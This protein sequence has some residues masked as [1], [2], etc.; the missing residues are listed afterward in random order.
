MRLILTNFN[1]VLGLRGYISFAENKPLLIY[2]ENIAGK[3]N[4][5]NVLRYCLIPKVKEKKGYTEEKRLNKNEILLEKNSVGNVEI[6]F[7]QREKFYKLYYSF[8][9]KS[10]N[11]G[12][13]QRLYE[14]DKTD[15]PERDEEKI[16]ALKNLPWK[17]LGVSSSKS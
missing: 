14:S 10:K 13:I 3:S 2:G 6:Y 4:I 7:E 15:L 12:Q 8:S 16:H 9:R 5:I 1:N 17:D 11:V